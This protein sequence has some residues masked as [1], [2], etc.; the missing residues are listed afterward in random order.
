MTKKKRDPIH[1]LPFFL[2]KTNAQN[3][4]HSPK[5]I[6]VVV[7]KFNGVDCFWKIQSKI[8]EHFLAYNSLE[9]FNCLASS[10][11]HAYLD[12][13][14]GLIFIRSQWSFQLESQLMGD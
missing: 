9:P 4:S 12:M 3:A 13:H 5:G 8:E 7:N 14:W 2:P 10:S 1:Y 11:D 6:Y